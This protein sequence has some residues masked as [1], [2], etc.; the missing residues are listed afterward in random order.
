MARVSMEDLKKEI[1][2]RQRALP[3][4]IAMRDA[5]DCRIVE[6]AALGAVEAAAKISGKRRRKAG[7]RARRMPRAGS[8]ASALMQILADKDAGMPGEVRKAKV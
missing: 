1:S 5:L 7:R 2:R 4:L 6:L 3:K 8:L